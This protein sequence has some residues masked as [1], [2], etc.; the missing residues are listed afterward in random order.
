MGRADTGG[1]PSAF[2]A[3]D[4]RR[5]VRGAGRPVQRDLAGGWTQVDSAGAAF[6]GVRRPQGEASL[7]YS[8]PFPPAGRIGTTLGRETVARSNSSRRVA[9]PQA[10]PNDN[11]RGN[12][13]QEADF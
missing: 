11:L 13:N 10:G 5:S 3:G 12:V 1:S 2:D 8:I 4:G 7:E 6:A 9:L